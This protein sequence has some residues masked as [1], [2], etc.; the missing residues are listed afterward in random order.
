MWHTAS[1]TYF[2]CTG[3]SVELTTECV[4]YGVAC[5]TLPYLLF[6]Q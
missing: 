1:V 3:V 5:L 6:Y 4:L 2:A